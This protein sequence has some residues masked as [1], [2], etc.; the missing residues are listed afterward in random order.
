[1][2]LQPGTPADLQALLASE[3]QRWGAVIRAANIQPD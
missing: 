3:I 2:R 1:V